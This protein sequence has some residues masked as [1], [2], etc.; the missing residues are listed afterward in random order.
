VLCM[1]ERKGFFKV[2]SGKKVIGRRGCAACVG[3]RLNRFCKSEI[4]NLNS[5]HSI[6][7]YG[8]WGEGKRRISRT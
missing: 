5:L 8:L 4:G 1:N 6:N 2:S 7:R 3:L